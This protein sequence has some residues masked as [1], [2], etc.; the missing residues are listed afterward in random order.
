MEEIWKDVVG[1]EGLYQVSNLGN[2]KSL[3]YNRTGEERI[4]KP[5]TDKDGYLQVNLYNNKKLKTFKIH[6]LVAKA[7]IP[8]PDN[9]PEVNHK[10]EDKTNNCLTNLEWMTR[11]ENNNYGTH[12]ER[13]SKSRINHQAISKSVIQYS[14]KGEFIRKWQS[15]MQIERDL[16]FSQ[17]HISECCKGKRKSAYGYIWTYA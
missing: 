8:N 12:N 13:S 15:A 3:N 6:R 9:K 7:F 16:G 11:L 2:I 4:L 1:Y 14:L 17:S 5:R 10:D